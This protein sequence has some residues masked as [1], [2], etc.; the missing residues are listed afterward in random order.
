MVNKNPYVIQNKCSTFFLTELPPLDE[1]GE[2]RYPR[3]QE[4]TDSVLV[5]VYANGHE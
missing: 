1:Q 3:L 2:Q 5:T 4:A